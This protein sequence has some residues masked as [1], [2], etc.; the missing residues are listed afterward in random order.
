MVGLGCGAPVLHRGAA[1]RLR[2]RR[3]R[4]W[5]PRD[6]RRLRSAPRTMPS[7]TPTSVAA[8]ARTTVVVG[9]SSSRCSP[10]KGSKR[11]LFPTVRHRP[12]ADLPGLV[13]L[14]ELGLAARSVD[15][16]ALTG[17][18]LERSDAIGPWLYSERVRRLMEDYAWR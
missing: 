18:G 13:E 2:V 14:E 1:L 10:A 7:A 6:P 3:R 9:T 17:S 15:R 5:R 12:F 16:L 4:P 8:S 11:R